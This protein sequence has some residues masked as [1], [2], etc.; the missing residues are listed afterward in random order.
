MVQYHNMVRPLSVRARQLSIDQRP[1]NHVRR[2]G[3]LA[4][5]QADLVATGG[6]FRWPPMDSSERHPPLACLCADEESQEH[7][8]RRL[9]CWTSQ[10]K[11]LRH[12]Q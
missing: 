12:I 8:E 2:R 6:R 5:E 7:L 4:T 9:N 1:D 11:A 10:R 3:G